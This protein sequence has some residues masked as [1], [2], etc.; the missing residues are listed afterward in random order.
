VNDH[1]APRAC[2]RRAHGQVSVDEDVRDRV[3]V[4]PPFSYFLFA[5]LF[6]LLPAAFAFSDYT[7]KSVPIVPAVP[8]VP[9]VLA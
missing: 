2:R 9:I 8:N 1:A 5:V 6:L 7:N 4:L 3:C